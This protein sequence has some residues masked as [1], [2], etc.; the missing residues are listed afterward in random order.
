MKKTL[1]QV[2]FSGLLRSG[3]FAFR[4]VW[5]HLSRVNFFT[6]MLM[7]VLVIPITPNS[8]RVFSRVSSSTILRVGFVLLD[9]NISPFTLICI[10]LWKKGP[11]HCEK[12]VKIGIIDQNSN[13]TTVLILKKSESFRNFQFLKIKR[14]FC[15][16]KVWTFF[17]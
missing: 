9:V 14:F 12:N 2:K 3:G 11:V 10:V 7:I 15:F 17:F 5:F 6:K 4:F 1:F 8:E 13:I 16:K